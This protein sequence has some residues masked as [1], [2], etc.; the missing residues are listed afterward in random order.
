MTGNR[1]L[2]DKPL[3]VAV[4]GAGTISVFHLTGWKQTP[5]VEV[6]A[7]CDPIPERASSLYIDLARKRRK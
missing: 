1:G 2:G 3:R 4:A 5:N 7:V 6:V